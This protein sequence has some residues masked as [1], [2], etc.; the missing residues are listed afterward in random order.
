M[1]TIPD[2]K[3]FNEILPA[4]TRI[5]VE[6]RATGYSGNR[7]KIYP[8]QTIKPEALSLLKRMKKLESEHGDWGR[9]DWYP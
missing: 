2:I 1:S 3:N 9:K 4:S 6:L 5:S 7:A 8:F